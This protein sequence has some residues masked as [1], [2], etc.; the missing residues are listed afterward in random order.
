MEATEFV[1]EVKNG[2]I[3]IPKEYRE[4]FRD[5]IRVIIM[6]DNKKKTDVS[7]KKFKALKLKT[8]NFKFDRDTANER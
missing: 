3:E 7:I 6:P 4:N 2:M 1:T 8:K 5:R